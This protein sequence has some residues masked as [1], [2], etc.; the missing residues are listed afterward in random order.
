M[1]MMMM[2]ISLI[3]L[4]DLSIEY[5]GKVIE[6]KAQE[7]LRWDSKVHQNEWGHG[8]LQKDFWRFVNESSIHYSR[9]WKNLNRDLTAF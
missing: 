3:L 9:D 5:R 1:M 2:M 4:G 7:L 6:W 8:H